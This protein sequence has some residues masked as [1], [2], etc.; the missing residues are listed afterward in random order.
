MP[1]VPPMRY[2]PGCGRLVDREGDCPFCV[3]EEAGGP[4]G[5]RSALIELALWLVVVL[6]VIAGCVFVLMI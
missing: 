3:T 1:R 5:R 2:C 6:L 4:G